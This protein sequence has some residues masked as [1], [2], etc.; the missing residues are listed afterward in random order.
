MAAVGS[1]AKGRNDR[2]FST[3]AESVTMP[4]SRT[5]STSPLRRHATS[6]RCSGGRS[7]CV[8]DAHVTA[9]TNA[10]YTSRVPLLVTSIADGV[11]PARRANAAQLKS[12]LR[13]TSF[14]RRCSS[15]RT[16]K[17]VARV[18]LG[19]AGAA[20][21]LGASTHAASAAATTIAPRVLFIVI[22]FI[23]P[24]DPSP[25]QAA[26]GPAALPPGGPAPLPLSTTLPHA[27]LTRGVRRFPYVQ[28]SVPHAPDVT[29]SSF[30]EVM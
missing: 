7:A 11:T 14:A 21:S 28:S 12:S 18:L 25:G 15:A 13:S 20:A 24:P 26:T 4:I 27:E 10:S 23:V 1:D 2:G 16:S 9:C 3:G 19:A 8:S 17:L 29:N 5:C 6:E 30:P 22:R